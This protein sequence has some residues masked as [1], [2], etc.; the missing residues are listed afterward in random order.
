M[1]KVSIGEFKQLMNYYIKNNI[2]LKDNGFRTVAIN[3]IGNA[4]LG[5]TSAIQQV[6]EENNM[7]FV[8][9]NLSQLDELGDLIGFPIKKYQIC[10]NNKCI[11]VTEKLL[12]SYLK[13][14]YEITP[15]VEPIMSYAIPEWVPTD[16]DTGTILL[17]DDFSRADPRFIQATMELISVGEYLSWKLPDN[18]LLVLSS[19]PDDGEYQVTSMDIAQKTRYVSFN[20]E[21]N[22]DEWVEWADNIGMNG[23]FINFF[24]MNWQEILKTSEAQSSRINPRSMEMFFNSLYSIVDK[25]ETEEGLKIISLISKGCFDENDASIIYSLFTQFITNK[26]H[27]VIQPEE[28][29]DKEKDWKKKKKKICDFCI[30]NEKVVLINISTLTN[31]VFNYVIKELNDSKDKEFLSSRLI[32]LLESDK[33]FMQEDSLFYNLTKKFDPSNIKHQD[34]QLKLLT[35][36]KKI[37]EILK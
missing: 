17:L 27:K 18:C 23:I 12:D 11:W 30:E 2:K 19:N 26:Y 16:S 25:L 33:E 13:A 22:I 14:G 3:A 8:K 35:N 21:F 4:G 5:K 24:Y 28:I 10:K 32:E 31:R 6:A 9:L 34:F 7:N 29:F 37:I 1:S 36:S 15:E 20:I